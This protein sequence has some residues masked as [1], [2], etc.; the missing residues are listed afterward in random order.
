MQFYS[1]VTSLSSFGTRVML[2]SQDD[3]EV[4]KFSNIPSLLFLVL[5]S[6]VIWQSLCYLLLLY[7]AMYGEVNFHHGMSETTNSISFSTCRVIQVT[8]FCLRACNPKKL[9]HLI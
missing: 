8:H 7:V 3:W 2:A 9:P 1:P 5:S 6:S 4:R